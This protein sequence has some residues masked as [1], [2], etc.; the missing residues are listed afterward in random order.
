VQL[1]GDAIGLQPQQVLA[2]LGKACGA[3][4]VRRFLPTLAAA[5][6]ARDQ[7]QRTFC[8][9]PVAKEFVEDGFKLARWHGEDAAWK[10]A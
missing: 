9:H 7:A 2:Q 6:H 4:A 1:Q 8:L 10:C 5:G 3:G